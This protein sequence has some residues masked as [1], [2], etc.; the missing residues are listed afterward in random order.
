MNAGIG[1]WKHITFFLF[2]NVKEKVGL[3][4]WESYQNARVS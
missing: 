1:G 4:I 3:H 2:H